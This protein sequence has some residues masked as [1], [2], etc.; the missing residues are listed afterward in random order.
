MQSM[1]LAPP[2]IRIL[3]QS[4]FSVLDPVLRVLVWTLPLHPFK[5]LFF[6]CNGF[7]RLLS[8]GSG[9]LSRFRCADWQNLSSC[10]CAT[11]AALFFHFGL[12]FCACGIDGFFVMGLVAHVVG[13]RLNGTLLVRRGLAWRLGVNGFPF[14]DAFIDCALSVAC[15]NNKHQARQQGHMNDLQS[16]PWNKSMVG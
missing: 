8:R 11:S 16:S 4:N 3:I 13:F 1:V 15:F 2:F 10:C 5:L 14:L 6:V 7:A 9:C 12:N